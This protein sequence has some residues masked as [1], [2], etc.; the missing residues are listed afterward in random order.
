MVP[1][2]FLSPYACQHLLILIFLIIAI[3]TGMRGY[4]YVFQFAL[5]WSF[6]LPGHL[7]MYLWP[8]VCLLWKN[9]CSNHLLIFQVDFFFPLLSCMRYLYVLGINHLANIWLANISSH[10]SGCLFILLLVS[11]A[12]QKVFSMMQSHFF[13][14]ALVAFDF[15]FRNHHQVLRQEAYPLFF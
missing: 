1:S 9:V 3:L 13:I 8:S 7:F 4:L 15:R 14:F 5:P 10:S 12:L 6:M 11:F 2:G